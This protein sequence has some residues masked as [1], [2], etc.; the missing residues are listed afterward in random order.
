MNKP[1]VILL[2]IIL[3]LWLLGASYC[4]SK[5]CPCKGEVASATVTPP[6]V[7]EKKQEISISIADPTLNF[8]AETADNLLFVKNNCDYKMPI[9]DDLKT[10]FSNV[11][12][13][14]TDNDNR[15]LTLFWLV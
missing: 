8:S 15:I 5:S 2:S 4:H 11:T 3:F 13:H 9:S 7:T 14:L 6:P 1:I 10:V 12:Q